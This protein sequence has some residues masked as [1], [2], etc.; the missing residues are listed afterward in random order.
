MYLPAELVAY[1]PLIAFSLIVIVL[2]YILVKFI[3]RRPPTNPKGSGLYGTP[4]WT[5][6][7]EEPAVGRASRD[8]ELTGFLPTKPQPADPTVIL[9][10]RAGD[11]T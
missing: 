4:K 3:E 1:L 11:A 8:P 7:A 5:R 2:M 10:T 6:E 9:Y